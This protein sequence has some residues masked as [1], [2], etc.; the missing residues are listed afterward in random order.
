MKTQLTQQ[1]HGFLYRILLCIVILSPLSSTLA[2]IL[3][4]DGA[5]TGAGDG[6]SWSDAFVDLLSALALAVAGDEIWVAAGTY[7]PGGPVTPI[8]T[9][10]GSRGANDQRMA[11]FQLKS[12]VTLYGGFLG[13]ETEREAR[14]STANPTILNGDLNSDDQAVAMPTRL[15]HHR[16]RWDNCYH[17]VTGTG[18]DG[19]AQLHG[20]TIT[21]GYANG[22]GN[23]ANGGGLISAAKGLEQ[24]GPTLIDC[25]IEWNYAQWSGGGLYNANTGLT[26]VS[27]IFRHNYSEVQGW[28]GTFAESAGVGGGGMHTRWADPLLIN[29][30]FIDNMTRGQGG[31]LLNQFGSPVLIG[32]QLAHN[33]VI[34]INIRHTGGGFWTGDVG[35][36]LVINC[37]FFGNQAHSGAGVMVVHGSRPTVVNAL[38]SGNGGASNSS[39]GGITIDLADATLINCTVTGNVSSEGPAG[40]EAANADVLTLRNS[41][42]WGNE[43][44]GDS[45]ANLSTPEISDIA[46]CCIQGGGG[47]GHGIIDLDPQFIDLDGPDDLIGTPDD[48]LRLAEQSPCI[49]AGHTTDLPADTQD[50]DGDGDIIEPLSLDLA[51]TTRVYGSGVD[52]GAYE[53]VPVTGTE[54]GQP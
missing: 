33:R 34:G 48:D 51:R 4:V 39:G 26:L 13:T 7:R 44:A 38:I 20:F 22:S 45:R 25:I 28:A 36:P 11:T 37:A 14:D 5:A 12:G 19:S 41:I 49:D 30:R 17:V 16:T 54:A 50:L 27:C 35:A 2:A 10:R 31:G 29:C 1:T 21:G 23:E 15:P 18:A 6:S 24:E 47:L 9:N 53:V 40:I 8:R 43:S 46:F 32:G 42:V 3:H 52:M